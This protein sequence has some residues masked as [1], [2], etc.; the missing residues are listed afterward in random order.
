MAMPR[1]L[2]RG[3]GSLI[4]S[5]P[6]SAPPPQPAASPSAAASAGVLRVD[7][8][9][10]RPNPQ[11]PREHFAHRDLDDLIASIKRHGILQPLVVT[12]TA[13]GYEL[14]AGER[15]L[16][17]ARMAGLTDVP[18][19]VRSAEEQ[20]KLELALVEN[21]Q[22]ADLNPIEEARA[23]RKLIDDYD[24]TQEIVA[25]RLG[26]SRPQVA[27]TLRLLDLPEEVQ[28]A[29]REGRVP[30]TAARALLAL[31]GPEQQLAWWKRL[32]QGDMTVR[33]VERGVRAA[34]G[35]P[36]RTDP[37]LAAAEE[38]LRAALGTKVDIHKRGPSGRI[39]IAFFSDEE[40]DALVR[41]LAAG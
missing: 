11:Q 17:A 5:G 16:R 39:A 20:D 37:N 23:Y 25:E 27:N 21:I 36:A 26:K 1:G 40:L 8:D 33:D 14:I 2:G 10:I 31:E 24:L 7:I 41:R 6:P 18:V 29:V 35:L 34:K 22:R 38:Q 12:K 28:S 3:L 13:D 30:V 9:Q 19:I 4:P 32:T 15:R